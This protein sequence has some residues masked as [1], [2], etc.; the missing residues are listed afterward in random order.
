MWRQNRTKPEPSNSIF[1]LQQRRRRRGT[2]TT[3]KGEKSARERGSESGDGRSGGSRRGARSRTAV[4]AA[5]RGGSARRD[6]LQAAAPVD[7]GSNSSGGGTAELTN[8]GRRAMAAA[9]GRTNER[10]CLE[11]RDAAPAAERGEASAQPTPPMRSGDGEPN[12][13]EL[14]RGGSLPEQ[15]I[16]AMIQKGEKSARER[17]RESGDGRSGQLAARSEVANGGSSCGEG[18]LG[19]TR[20]A[21]QRARRTQAA[22]PAAARTTSSPAM[23]DSSGGYGGRERAGAGA[24]RMRH[25]SSRWRGEAATPARRLA[26]RRAPAAAPARRDSG[27]GEVNDV[28]QRRGGT[29]PEQS[30]PGST[31]MAQTRSTMSQFAFVRGRA[32]P[33]PTFGVEPEAT[34]PPL[35]YWGCPYW[36]PLFKLTYGGGDIP[37]VTFAGGGSPTATF[38]AATPLGFSFLFFT[39]F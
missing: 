31:A 16:P 11:R 37:V 19:E 18:S 12:D 36:R 29:L 28:E 22:T 35:S 5:R 17:G 13:V 26:T 32:L 38:V 15:S 8:D 14:R 6:A 2:K 23:D 34:P 33:F 1:R 39:R 25:R 21:P 24:S 4:P 10:A 30:I 3:I 9:G 20:R 7:Y 27:D